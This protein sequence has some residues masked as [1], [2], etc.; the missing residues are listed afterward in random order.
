[1]AGTVLGTIHGVAKKAILHAV[2]VCTWRAA[3][4]ILPASVFNQSWADAHLTLAICLTLATCLTPARGRQQTPTSH[5][6]AWW[7][8]EEAHATSHLVAISLSCLWTS[9]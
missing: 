9:C 2:K 7:Q 8:A 4:L 6:H 5:W 1:M 3:H